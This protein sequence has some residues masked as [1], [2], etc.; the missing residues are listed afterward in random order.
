MKILTPPPENDMAK[1]EAQWPDFGRWLRLFVGRHKPEGWREVG[2]AA[3]K[4]PAFANS[5]ANV[6]GTNAV[7]AFYKDSFGLV[8]IK[9]RVDSGA[10]NTAIFTLPEKYW[11]DEVI[12]F[13]NMQG[14]AAIVIRVNTSGEVSPIGAVSSNNTSINCSFRVAQ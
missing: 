3:G 10:L 4:N 5:W 1:I 14:A 8:H 2:D 11:P 7:A 6:G 12:F 13:A 9:G